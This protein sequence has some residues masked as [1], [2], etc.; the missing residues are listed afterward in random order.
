MHSP[1]PVY[2][3]NVTSLYLLKFYL[4]PTTFL[5][6][7]RLYHIFIGSHSTLLTY[8]GGVCGVLGDIKY[9]GRPLLVFAYPLYL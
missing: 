4:E 3:R 9:L 5:A 6:N 8:H 2:A 7:G 1:H